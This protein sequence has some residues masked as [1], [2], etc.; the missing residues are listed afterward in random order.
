[1]SGL[2]GRWGLIVIA[3]PDCERPSP[4]HKPIN[5]DGKNSDRLSKTLMKFLMVQCFTYHQICSQ[6]IKGTLQY[7]ARF[8]SL[9][10]CMRKKNSCLFFV[11]STTTVWLI[12]KTWFNLQRCVFLNKKHIIKND[13]RPSQD[14]NV[15]VL[16]WKPSAALQCKYYLDWSNQWPND[17]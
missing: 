16:H 6:L 9:N 5:G 1:M 15:Y 13:N 8:V 4:G 3:L 12:F 2:R 14:T 11:S 7:M 17:Q 10:F